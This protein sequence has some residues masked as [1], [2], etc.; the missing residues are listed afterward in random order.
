M[1]CCV[2]G[3]GWCC[4]FGSAV[5]SFCSFFSSFFSHFSRFPLSLPPFD[6]TDARNRPNSSHTRSQPTATRVYLPAHVGHTHE[7]VDSRSRRSG[8]AGIASASIACPQSTPIDKPE[9]DRQQRHRR[10]HTDSSAPGSV[11]SSSGRADTLHT[12]IGLHE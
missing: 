5:V 3:V 12:D 1:V 8:A 10:Q 4:T 7:R 11:S 6:S 2:R 9:R